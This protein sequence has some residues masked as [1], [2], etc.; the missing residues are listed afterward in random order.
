MPSLAIF[1]ER[2]R[3]EE[4]SEQTVGVGVSAKLEFPMKNG[5]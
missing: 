1:D 5:R 3:A 4:S 2:M